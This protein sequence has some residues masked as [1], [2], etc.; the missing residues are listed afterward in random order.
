[1]MRGKRCRTG[2]QD[3]GRHLQRGVVVGAMKKRPRFGS[4]RRRNR[5]GCRHGETTE[6]ETSRRS[7]SG[8]AEATGHRRLRLHLQRRHQ[9]QRLIARNSLIPEKSAVGAEKGREHPHR[10]TMSERSSVTPDE[11]SAGSDRGHHRH[12]APTTVKR[13]TFANIDLHHRETGAATI[14]EMLTS[15]STSI[16][17]AMSGA[18][19]HLGR[20]L[21]VAASLSGVSVKSGLCGVKGHRRLRHLKRTSS[22][23]KSSSASA[24]SALPRPNLRHA[25]QRLSQ[26]RLRQRL[27]TQS[28]GLQSYKK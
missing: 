20:D 24:R 15:T 14:V 8:E 27:Q 23:S 16:S 19:S 10:G 4:R 22:V 25:S 1:M 12:E 9:G 2:I 6:I 5:S 3:R 18:P 17:T 26:H 7:D 28:T 13:L 11:K 21:I